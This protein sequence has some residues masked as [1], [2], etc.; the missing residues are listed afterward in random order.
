MLLYSRNQQNFINQPYFSLKSKVYICTKRERNLRDYTAYKFPKITQHD[1][2]PTSL[3]KD[4]RNPFFP[5]F[6]VFFSPINLFSMYYSCFIVWR[7]SMHNYTCDKTHVVL[8]KSQKANDFCPL[9]SQCHVSHAPVI[10]GTH[11][12]QVQPQG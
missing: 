12:C 6:L 4:F 5:L 2:T 3:S 10:K 8:R 9:L 7:S 1:K 11:S